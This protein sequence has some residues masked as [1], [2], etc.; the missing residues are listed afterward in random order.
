MNKDQS[1]EDVSNQKIWVREIQAEETARAEALWQ[2]QAWCV[3]VIEKMLVAE[4][5]RARESVEKVGWS[6]V[7]CAEAFEF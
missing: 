2:K 7:S 4:A 1:R 3:P 6:V 5:C